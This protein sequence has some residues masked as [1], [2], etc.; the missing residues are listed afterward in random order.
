MSPAPGFPVPPPPMVWSPRPMPRG[1]VR[2]FTTIST[3]ATTIITPTTPTT[4]RAP[5]TTTAAATT[6][7]AA[8][9]ATAA[10]TTTTTTIYYYIL[11]PFLL[12]L[13][14]LLLLLKPTMYVHMYAPTT[15]HRGG[16]RIP[17]RGGEGGT[18]EA[19]L[20]YIQQYYIYITNSKRRVNPANK[21]TIFGISICATFQTSTLYWASR[22]CGCQSQEPAVLFHGQQ[23]KGSV[24]S[25]WVFPTTDPFT[26][27]YSTMDKCPHMSKHNI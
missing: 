8:A 20:I 12:P 13:P 10:A 17:W 16:G 6:A 15:G 19:W 21:S 14:L 2:A 22:L 25:G 27:I 11:C 1:G 5:P 23:Q 9:A 7:A 26:S 24:L 18:S 3:I 4:P